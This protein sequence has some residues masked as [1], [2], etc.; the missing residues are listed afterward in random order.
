[1][2]RAAQSAVVPWAS[3]NEQVGDQARTRAQEFVANWA[4]DTG[5]PALGLGA[6]HMRFSYEMGYLRGHGRGLLA[7]AGA[8]LKGEPL[9]EADRVSEWSRFAAR[10]FLARWS[11]EMSA[12]GEVV[13]VLVAERMGLAYEA[14]YLRGHGAGL[15]RAS[16]GLC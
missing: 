14:G 5:E 3:F 7:A 10:E 8:L 9:A 4:C 11:R 6:D 12:V 2:T 1:M 15:R 16:C 13:R